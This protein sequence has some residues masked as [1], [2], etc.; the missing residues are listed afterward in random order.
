MNLTK[1]NKITGVA[2]VLLVL[3]LASCKGD[4]YL[5]ALPA[6]ATALMAVDLE[7]SGINVEAEGLD[8]SQKIYLFETNDGMLGMVAQCTSDADGFKFID[9]RWVCGYDHGK[10][11]V[12]GPVLPA[13]REETERRITRL[14]EQ[15]EEDSAVGEFL[16]NRLD[17]IDAPIAL[18]AQSAALPEDFAAP[19]TLGAPKNTDPSLVCIEA[20]MTL[21]DGVLRI[22]GRNFSQNRQLDAALAES[23]KIFRPL[24]G[25]F[26]QDSKKQ[27]F[28][29]LMNVEGSQL[30]PL[31]QQNGGLQALLAGINTAVD[32]DN[33]IRSV[34]G[35]MALMVNNAQLDMTMKAQLGKTDFLKDIDYWK[36]SCPAGSRIIDRGRNQWTF[37]NG[38]MEFRFEVTDENTFIGQLV[39]KKKSTDPG[40]FDT[41][42]GMLKSY[43]GDIKSIIYTIDN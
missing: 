35:D 4:S 2:A 38:D 31:M 9:N 37:D 24:K 19:F 11:V 5:N 22:K 23:A 32:M 42:L 3:L 21:Q 33:I 39:H 28:S 8:K 29:L 41:A 15:D 13:Q 27:L 30:L 25:A 14:L 12:L 43:V 40:V 34:D 7:K 26:E 20:Q 36:S 6:K 10:M 18:V 16:F 17:S 1:L